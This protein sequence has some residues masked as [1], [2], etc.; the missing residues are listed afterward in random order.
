ML[1]YLNEH[2]SQVKY[3][4]LP[5]KNSI[6]RRIKVENADSVHCSVLNGKLEINSNKDFKRIL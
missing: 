2:I 6:H 5:P 3:K 1:A 4:I